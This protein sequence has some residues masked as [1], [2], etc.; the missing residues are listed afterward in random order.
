MRLAWPPSLTFLVLTPAYSLAT[1]DARNVLPEF[2]SHADAVFNIQRVALF[3]QAVQGGNYALLKAALQDR[4]HQPFRQP[5]VPGL[6]ELLA[7]EHPDLLGVCLSGA[8]PSIVAFAERN[9]D[10]VES[11]L[12][13]AFQSQCL[14]YTIRRLRAHQRG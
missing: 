10:G 12:C 7:L 1:A 14:P 2:I 6:A 4:L 9:L 8:G 13:E 5:L 3:L 11:A